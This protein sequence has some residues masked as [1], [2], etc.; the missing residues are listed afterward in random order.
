M[1]TMHVVISEVQAEMRQN[2]S[3]VQSSIRSQ[4]NSHFKFKEQEHMEAT[5]GQGETS[6]NNDPIVLTATTGG[7]AFQTR[8]LRLELPRLDGEDP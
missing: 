1:Q 2:Q 7:D 8:P 3:D 5:Q 6:R 4:F